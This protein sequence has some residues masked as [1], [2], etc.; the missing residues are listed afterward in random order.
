MST[1]TFRLIRSEPVST[2]VRSMHC[3]RCKRRLFS[4]SPV[5]LMDVRIRCRR[6]SHALDKW[7]VVHCVIRATESPTSA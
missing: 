7:V 6:C 3:P 2:E 5:G 1:I 4:Y